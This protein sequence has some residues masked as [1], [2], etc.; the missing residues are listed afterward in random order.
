M[1]KSTATGDTYALVTR[2]TGA[3]TSGNPF[4]AQQTSCPAGADPFVLTGITTLTDGAL[5]IASINEIDNF[6]A[7]ATYTPATSPASLTSNVFLESAIGSD[8]ATISGSAIKTT[9]GAT[10]NISIDP[11]KAPDEPCGIVLSLKPPTT[12]TI[13]PGGSEPSNATIAPGASITDLDNFTLKTDIGSDT[14]TGATVT[15]APAEAFNNI[16]QVDITNTSNTAQCT[17]I[18][19][20]ASNTVTFSSC[21]LGITTSETTYK[22][23]IT[24]K[25]HADMPA[26]PGASYDTTGTVT[27][28]TTTNSQTGSDTG[29]ATIKVD[30]GSP[31]NSTDNGGTTGNAQV[32]INYTTPA[33][34]DLHSVVVLQDTSAVTDNPVEGTT[35]TVGNTIGTATVACVDTTVSVSTADSCTDTDVV[36]DTAYHYEIFV[37]DS[38]GNYATGVVPTSS[39]FTPTAATPTFTL[40]DY[41][42]YVDNDATN[43]TDAWGD[44]DLA[45][46]AAIAAIPA[47]NDP[48]N[49]TQELRLRV[50]FTVNTAALSA[51]SQQF[52]IQ[53][54][55]GT[56]SDCTTG[57][58]TDIGASATWEFA[59]STVTDGVAITASLAESEIAGQYAKSNPTTTNTNSA[60]VGQ[61]IE[62]DFHIIGTNITDA[63]QY[64]FR[65]IESDDTV[66][67]AYTTCPT[68]RTEPGMANFMRHGNFF[69]PD[70]AVEAGLFWTE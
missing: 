18:T 27:S 7:S 56:D 23:R 48:P 32:T 14:M 15:L 26:I 28:I 30:N 13:G 49:S 2:Y 8:G 17:A 3:V 19:N 1:D 57:S 33:D 5:V 29:S 12:V 50:N 9:A 34:A 55:A 37:K 4:E 51:T 52:K 16:A 36:N 43:P 46:N 38:N 22:I 24:P 54:K 25:A 65:I 53:F 47:D 41:R 64:S 62:Y 6:W 39:P 21:S 60:T 70:T 61:E 42:W 67:D 59:T 44:P 63:T 68:L 11:N 10:G 35:Y 20:P 40:K 58:W 66:F 69:T 31:G 45:E